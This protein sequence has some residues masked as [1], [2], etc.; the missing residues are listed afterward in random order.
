ME[1]R[2]DSATHDN[3]Q[4]SIET[5][6]SR[7]YETTNLNQRL[8][9]VKEKL[10]TR[11]FLRKEVKHDSKHNPQVLSLIDQD[12][13]SLREEERRLVEQLVQANKSFLKQYKKVVVALSDSER[14]GRLQQDLERAFNQKIQDGF[15]TLSKSTSKETQQTL[16]AYTQ[17]SLRELDNIKTTSTN[18]ETRLKQHIEDCTKTFDTISSDMRKSSRST[19][20]SSED[21]PIDRR[22]MKD[23]K[24][25]H[26]Y[27]K[28]IDTE[29]K[30][31]ANNNSLDIV[32]T[33]SKKWQEETAKQIDLLHKRN[34]DLQRK[35]L[36]LENIT[37]DYNRRSSE[38]DIVYDK[39]KA[40]METLK[41]ESEN[42]QARA[43][44]TNDTQHDITDIRTQ[45]AELKAEMSRKVTDN[46]TRSDIESGLSY[47]NGTMDFKALQILES[48]IIILEQTYKF[49]L[50][51]L[52]D[53]IKDLSQERKDGDKNDNGKRPRTHDL[54]TAS[55]EIKLQ[56]DKQAVQIKELM[57]FLEPLRSTVL[58][59]TF[60][61][62]LQTSMNQL[63]GVA[64]RHESDIDHIYTALKEVAHAM[65]KE[66]PSN[67]NPVLELTLKAQVNT[68]ERRVKEKHT[69]I[70]E[71]LE[72]FKSSFTKSEEKQ[73]KQQIQIDN[74]QQQ[75]SLRN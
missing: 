40:Q 21:Y 11:S 5:V 57:A 61:E 63:I 39:I 71:T 30:G 17:H 6:T 46:D 33:R 55:S 73:Q 27:L 65:P 32:H 35:S 37:R 48:R 42:K 72:D 54:E 24:E 36:Q 52:E 56:M 64:R 12:I 44:N 3:L 13:K 70:M 50:K 45:L 20:S 25:F 62:N 59:N 9:V 1:T 38:I 60:A 18:L 10:T 22:L 29:G 69:L 2:L 14:G 74:L 7:L 43:S 41:K 26:K 67:T 4:S 16:D 68:H 75:L 23:V 66:K 34:E 31:I 8:Q 19:S 49:K 53:T 58:G 28:R 47:S 15:N 51:E